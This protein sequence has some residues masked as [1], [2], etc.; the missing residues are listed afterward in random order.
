VEKKG[1]LWGRD[2]RSTGHSYRFFK[3]KKTTKEMKF[4]QTMGIGFKEASDSQ[5]VRKRDLMPNPMARSLPSKP[6]EVKRHALCSHKAAGRYRLR[7]QKGKNDE[8]KKK[9]EKERRFT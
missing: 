6:G 1:C 8:E 7:R 5:G 4:A 9:H 3:Y 2:E